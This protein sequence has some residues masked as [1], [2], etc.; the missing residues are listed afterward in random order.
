MSS[1][2]S[3]GERPSAGLSQLLATLPREANKLSSGSSD[4]VDQALTLALSRDHKWLASE[5]LLMAMVKPGA[6][7]SKAVNDILAQQQVSAAAVAQNIERR[8]LWVRGDL[9]SGQEKQPAWSEAMVRTMRLL[10]IICEDQ[11][12]QQQAAEADASAL[13]L[14][15]LMVEGTSLAAQV[16]DRLSQGRINSQTMLRDIGFRNPSALLL[17]VSRDN[18][19]TIVVTGE[20]TDNAKPRLWG[21]CFGKVASEPSPNDSSA[22]EPWTPSALPDP[23]DLRNVKVPIEGETNWVLPGRL[24]I[25][26]LPYSKDDVKSL[27]GAGIT[28]FVS[29]VGEMGSGGNYVHRHYPKHARGLL[30]KGHSAQVSYRYNCRWLL[31]NT[32]VSLLGIDSG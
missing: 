18:F 8:P 15:A 2:S 7:Q 3:S 12:D 19:E 16:V 26:S 10:S 30:P 31:I 23:E 27:L 20:E 32:G 14:A 25:G 6:S 22:M 21:G 4:L 24:L 5:H 29:L 28:T 1:R 17:E 13:V 9:V 11:K